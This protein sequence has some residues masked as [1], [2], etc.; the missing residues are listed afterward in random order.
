LVEAN[1]EGS[2][3]NPIADFFLRSRS[4][5]VLPRLVEEVKRSL[6]TRRS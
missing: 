2:A 4:G 6:G 5:E 1:V 3:I